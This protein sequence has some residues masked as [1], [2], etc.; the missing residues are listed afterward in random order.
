MTNIDNM[1]MVE[2][3]CG[4]D[5]SV[6]EKYGFYAETQHNERCLTR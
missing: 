2:D 6:R 4:K 1:D 5:G 3:P